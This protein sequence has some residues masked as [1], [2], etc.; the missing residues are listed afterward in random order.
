MLYTHSNPVSKTL[1]AW[2][3]SLKWSEIL[4]A[5]FYLGG[6]FNP[7]SLPGFSHLPTTVLFPLDP[8]EPLAPVVCFSLLLPGV[9]YPLLNLWLWP[10]L[11]TCSCPVLGQRF[12]HQHW[13]SPVGFAVCS[14]DLSFSLSHHLL[15]GPCMSALL[16]IIL[17]ISSPVA[18]AFPV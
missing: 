10:P 1:R 4:S 7:F 16:S 15:P 13:A 8:K 12:H 5:L 3:Q 6:L 17:V 14:W 9:F 2:S 11:P 18:S